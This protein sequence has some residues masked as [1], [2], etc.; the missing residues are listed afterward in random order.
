MA[1]ANWTELKESV[2]NALLRS[3][4]ADAEARFIDWLVKFEAHARRELAGS[5]MGELV[6]DNATIDSEYTVTPNDM[7]SVRSV[8]ITVN[9]TRTI[10]RAMSPAAM[11][12][13]FRGVAGV[14][15]AFAIIG[16][17]LRLAPP[18]NGTYNVRMVYTALP[19]LT[20]SAPT[21]WLLTAAPDVYEDGVLA[22]AHDY[23]ED[24]PGSAR[25]MERANAGIAGLIKQAKRNLPSAGL[26]P[27]VVGGVV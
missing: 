16:T 22:Y 23:Y 3:A 11:D 26:S 1:L 18:P 2:L 15:E 7:I 25:R 19:A 20:F 4:D 14:P 17:A 9:G 8:A 21:N 27:R 12:D 5:N 10:L 24:E 6:A 13:E